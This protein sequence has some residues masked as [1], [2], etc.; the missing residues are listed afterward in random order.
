MPGIKHLVEC[1]CY[2]KIF[3][4]NEIKTNHKF[5]V[6]SKLDEN[7]NVIPKLQNCNNCESLHYVYDICKSELRPGK[8]DVGTKL[9]K[10]DFIMMLPDK[11]AN[12]LIKN[13][14][15]ISDFEHALDIIEEKSWGSY[16]VIKRDI[17]GEEQQVKALLFKDENTIKIINKEIKSLVFGE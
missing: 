8:E 17:V 6:Y 7:D 5:P 10:E 11:V 9:D 16:I 4:K 13:R 12:I 2:L 15:D 14:C 3:G 1:H